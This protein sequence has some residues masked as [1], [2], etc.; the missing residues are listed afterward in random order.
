MPSPDFR[1]GDII[2]LSAKSII[3][4]NNDKIIPKMPKEFTPVL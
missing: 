4:F 3:R 2:I 1:H